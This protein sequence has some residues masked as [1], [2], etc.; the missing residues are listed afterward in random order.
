MS[1]AMTMQIDV[2]ELLMAVNRCDYFANDFVNRFVYRC[3][4]END[5]GNGCEY[6]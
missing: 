6:T 4:C 1:V 3:K 2:S 5:A